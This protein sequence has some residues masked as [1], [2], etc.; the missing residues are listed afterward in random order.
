MYIYPQVRHLGRGKGLNEE[1][2]K[3]TEKG[4]SVAKKVISLTQI[5]LCTFFCNSNPSFL[6][7]HEAL[8][9]L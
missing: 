1:S 6:R 5:L 2:N 3:K 8:M 9:K 7:F 4:E